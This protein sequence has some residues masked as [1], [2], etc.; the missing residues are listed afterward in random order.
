MGIVR[1][2]QLLP[3]LRAFRGPAL[4]ERNPFF[5]IATMIDGEAELV[6]MGASH[7]MPLG[8]T[9]AI[10]ALESATDFSV[11]NLAIEGGGVLPK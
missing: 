11:A 9:G 5:Q 1:L 7:A 6:V 3:L 2:M 4:S 8:F 10:D